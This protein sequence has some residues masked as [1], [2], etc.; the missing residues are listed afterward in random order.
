MGKNSSGVNINACL[1]LNAVSSGKVT[2]PRWCWLRIMLSVCGFFCPA[3]TIVLPA[4]GSTIV[5]W[6]MGKEHTTQ[7]KLHPDDTI[8]VTSGFS[9]MSFRNKEPKVTQE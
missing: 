4:E 2:K 6:M 8:W 9:F 5:I 1:V 3:G 7:K